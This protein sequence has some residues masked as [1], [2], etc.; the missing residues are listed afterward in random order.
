[1]H[2]E[3]QTSINMKPLAKLLD[4]W[5]FVMATL[6]SALRLVGRWWA[7]V[8]RKWI[9]IIERSSEFNEFSYY[10]CIV[11]AMS[12]PA[13]FQFAVMP[14]SSHSRASCWMIQKKRKVMHFDLTKF[15]FYRTSFS[16]FFGVRVFFL[17]ALL[18]LR[19]LKHAYAKLNVN[20]TSSSIPCVTPLEMPLSFNPFNRWET[21][22]T[23]RQHY[24]LSAAPFHSLSLFSSRWLPCWGQIC[25]ILSLF[26][27]V[28]D[29]FYHIFKWNFQINHFYKLL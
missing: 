26:K 21:I 5:S 3:P 29:S 27:C 18:R 17:S 12:T 8:W 24:L 1:M 20:Q 16:M 19:H 25:N 22:E 10:M 4:V 11:H 2:L 28:H 9:R 6:G 14:V 13:S 7:N 15:I 23:S